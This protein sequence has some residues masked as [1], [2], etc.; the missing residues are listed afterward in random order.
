M[1]ILSALGLALLPQN[2]PAAPDDPLAWVPSNA[3]LV[4]RLPDVAGLRAAARSNVHYRF[5]TE[6]DGLAA[7]TE[8]WR[9]GGDLQAFLDPT[10]HLDHASENVRKLAELA[11][12]I[13]GSVTHYLAELPEGSADAG[14][15]DFFGTWESATIVVPERAMG[16]VTAVF[17]GWAR[18]E[19]R[20]VRVEYRRG[21]QVLF[22]IGD[23]E[24]PPRGALLL[25]DD[26]F[27]YLMTHRRAA[28]ALD[29][30]VNRFLG[31]AAGEV[32]GSI[33]EQASWRNAAAA[34]AFEPHGSFWIAP[35][36]LETPP[37]EPSFPGFL[38]LE[39]ID[40][41]AGGAR[42][43][44]GESTDAEIRVH[45]PEGARVRQLLAALGPAPL[46]LFERFPGDAVSV[47]AVQL[48]PGRLLGEALVLA[49][50]YRAGTGEVL[51]DQL[52]TVSDLFGVDLEEDVVAQLT[53]AM[54]SY[55]PALEN[56]GAGPSAS[57]PGWIRTGTF[58][59]ELHGAEI[60]RGELP[61]LVEAAGDL[62][63]LP[64]GV[65]TEDAGADPEI[66]FD[67][68][69]S[70]VD[71]DVWEDGGGAW[72]AG[73]VDRAR[74]EALA[75]QAP[76]TSLLR[77]ERLGPLLRDLSAASW[78]QAGETAETYGAFG[79]FFL[80]LL[81]A[82]RGDRDGALGPEAFRDTFRGVT[83]TSLEVLAGHLSLH[84]R[85]R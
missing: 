3:W 26:W 37:E 20:T 34:R 63:G 44:P 53:G 4:A 55:R 72:L 36:V 78:L 11:A 77:S 65:E 84:F 16:E 14:L 7:G 79:G 6:P 64:V 47:S 80:G 19:S 2:P 22:D 60:L 74:L 68:D 1:L 33:L 27:A 9:G 75:L 42:F 17:D 41:V 28:E 31:R 21:V 29:P 24:T 59:A 10:E 40:W 25:G 50:E 58:L 5:L 43:G 76:E 8:T 69:G 38:G 82:R 51:E 66:V 30:F 48:D 12:T 49:N 23:G 73:S 67:F 54:G 56:D 70:S 62:L 45:V 81:E 15:F 57:L 13:E 83:A 32:E 35:W 18:E 39:D 52:S 61:E 85:T 46:H 71:L